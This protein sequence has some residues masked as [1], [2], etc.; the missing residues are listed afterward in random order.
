MSN[1]GS[2]VRVASWRCGA[3]LMAREDERFSDVGHESAAASLPCHWAPCEA[4]HTASQRRAADRAVADLFG[5]LDSTAAARRETVWLVGVAVRARLLRS[6]D[7]RGC[8]IL[9]RFLSPSRRRRSL[10]RGA[11]AAF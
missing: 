5:G 7:R 10:E 8:A 2:I 1:I 6:D 9:P 4:A 11:G 3:I